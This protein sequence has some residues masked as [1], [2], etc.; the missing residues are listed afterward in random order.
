[1]NKW[2]IHLKVLQ[3]EKTPNLPVSVCPCGACVCVCVCVCVGVFMCMYAHEYYP[4]LVSVQI[5]R[6]VYSISVFSSGRKDY[7]SAY[8]LPYLLPSHLVHHHHSLCPTRPCSI[9]TLLTSLTPSPATISLTHSAPAT[10]TSLSGTYFFF[11]KY[12]SQSEHDPL[13]MN[14][15]SWIPSV[16]WKSYYLL[17]SFVRIG[18]NQ[19][20]NY[21]F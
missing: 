14:W 10:L 3:A 8:F 20:A 18:Y 16:K 6:S 21:Y 11:K 2:M 15:S 4:G 1:M 7:K 13:R 17:H 12:V 19:S 9:W 5:L